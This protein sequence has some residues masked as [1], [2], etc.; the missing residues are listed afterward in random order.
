M[1]VIRQLDFEDL[2]QMIN[3][4]IKIQ[5]YDKKYINPN[6]IVLNEN[7]LR[8]KT[9]QYL[10]QSLNNNLFMFGYFIN[11]KL[12]ANCGFYVDKHFP[13]YDNPSGITGYICNVFTLEKYR[14]NGYQKKLFTV[15][16]ENAKKMGITNFELSSMNDNAIKMYKSF[17]FT[18]NDHKYTYKV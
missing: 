5:D 12:V 18:N 11:N 4:R 10:K 14:K 9:N 15:C 16:F 1:E 8:K 13:T 2:D 6:S 3:L 7:E 17:G